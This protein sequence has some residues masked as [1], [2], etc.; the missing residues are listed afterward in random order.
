MEVNILA[1]K[2]PQRYAVRRT[3]VAA[4]EELRGRFPDLQVDIREVKRVDKIQAY[5]PVV[6]YPSLVVNGAL[7]C[8]GRFPR[9]DEV[10]TWLCQ[11][12]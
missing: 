3:V 7:V 2:N 9:K 10:V 12:L 1:I 8:S 6:I 11:A 4:C 5:T